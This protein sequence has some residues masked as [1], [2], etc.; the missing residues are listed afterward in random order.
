[1]PSV[2]GLALT[3]QVFIS[4]RSALSGEFTAE[5]AVIHQELGQ[6]IRV[7]IIHLATHGLNIEVPKVTKV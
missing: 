1:M 4:I 6:I 5:K 2:L 3:V 7:I